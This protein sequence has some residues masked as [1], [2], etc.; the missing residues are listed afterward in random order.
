MI[1]LCK[2]CVAFIAPLESNGEGISSTPEER[3]RIY[4]RA[5]TIKVA[6]Y[7]AT[8]FNM[9][10][11]FYLLL[12]GHFLG[13]AALTFGALLSL[14]LSEIARAIQRYSSNPSNWDRFVRWVDNTR[15]ERDFL[16]F[17]QGVANQTILINPA[18]QRVNV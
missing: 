18:L 8:F 12:H 3:N 7:A 1:S 2:S 15:T 6:A 4:V 11:S 10:L 17:F 13:S 9:I 5:G 14:D 16:S